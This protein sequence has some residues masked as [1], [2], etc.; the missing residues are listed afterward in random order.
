MKK[1]LVALMLVLIL[2]IPA[3]IAAAATYYRVNTTS[4]K[5]RSMPNDNS[6]IIG[7]YRKDYALTI[8]SKSGDWSYVT[9]SNGFKGYVLTKYLVKASS[10]RAWIA[11]DKT[12][13][14]KGPDGNFSAIATLA[15][16]TKITVL[17]HGSKYDYVSAGEF[18][19]G[20][21]VNCR[22]SKKKV[23]SSGNQ[24]TS[25]QSKAVDYYGWIASTSK[26]KLRKSANTSAP[27]V[28]TV[29]PGTKVHV[30]YE[31]ATWCKVK[32]SGNTGW[33]Q[34]KFISKS[35][36]ADNPSKPKP[37]T[38]SPYTAYVVSSNKK[39]VNVRKGNSTNYAVVFKVNYGE[40]VTVLKHNAKWDYIE[41]KG[42]KGYIQNSFLQLADPN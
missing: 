15:K 25:N 20:Y 39:P 7:S 3:G 26:L 19:K 13:L 5:V 42:K 1:R 33:V 4:L 12:A 23:A 11:Y 30:V 6:K 8:K 14:R 29:K 21:V 37:T 9:F 38:S 28:T 32:V 36:P 24:S 16:G 34:K 41:Y 2:V 22:I 18:G 27:V 35:K 10:Y 31:T 17:A 40:A